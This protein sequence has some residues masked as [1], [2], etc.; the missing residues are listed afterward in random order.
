[1]DDRSNRNLTKGERKRARQ[2]AG[3]AW[4]RELAKALRDLDGRFQDWRDGKI[5]SFELADTIHRFHDGPNRDLYKLYN[6]LSPEQAT[7][8]AVGLRIVA[9]DEVPEQIRETLATSIEFWSS[10]GFDDK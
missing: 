9:G 7:A 2:I 8:R 6:A 4:E 1:M 5:D 3:I 10:R